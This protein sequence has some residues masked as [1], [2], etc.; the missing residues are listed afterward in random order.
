MRRLPAS[1]CRLIPKPEQLDR[2]ERRIIQL[3]MEQQAL[4][5]EA[6]AASVQRLISSIRRSKKRIASTTSWKRC[7]KPR[8]S[9]AGTQH[10]KA[11]LEK[12]RQE[13]EVASRAQDLGRMSELGVMVVSLN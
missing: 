2:L 12:A 1:G 8:K 4:M 11:Q 6:D 5:K 10:I 7:G 9:L 13:F 3:K